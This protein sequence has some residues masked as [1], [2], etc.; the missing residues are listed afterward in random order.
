[1][2]AEQRFALVL[3]L[4]AGIP[5]QSALLWSII[6]YLITAFVYVLNQIGIGVSAP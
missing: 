1:M 5:M 3:I 6:G 4:V 2:N